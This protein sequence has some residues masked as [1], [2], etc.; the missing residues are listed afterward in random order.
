MTLL[1]NVLSK[2]IEYRHTLLKIQ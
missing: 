2:V 1:L